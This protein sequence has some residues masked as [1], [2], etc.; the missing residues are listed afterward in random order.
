MKLLDPSH[1]V[2]QY[3][4]VVTAELGEV[5]RSSSL[6]DLASDMTK[7]ATELSGGIELA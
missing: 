6:V 4:Q 5:H 3:T 7:G 2:R 1:H